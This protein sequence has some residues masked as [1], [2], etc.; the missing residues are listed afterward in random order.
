MEKTQIAQLVSG[1]KV[2]YMGKTAE[3]VRCTES[4]RG[5]LLNTGSDEKPYFITVLASELEEA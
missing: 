2:K 1:Q 3:F 5:V 4:G